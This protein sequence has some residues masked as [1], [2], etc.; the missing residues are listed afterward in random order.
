M[1]E[2]LGA[3]EASPRPGGKTPNLPVVPNHRESHRNE[4][5]A[6]LEKHQ[7]KRKRMVRVG[8]KTV[9]TK[10]VCLKD[11]RKKRMRLKMNQDSAP[12]ETLLGVTKQF[13]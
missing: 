4:G 12:E 8:M 2:V 13:S 11:M 6:I 10:V 5:A 7:T 3:T 1:K 9:K